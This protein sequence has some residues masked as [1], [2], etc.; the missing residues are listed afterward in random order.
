MEP[1]SRNNGIN[2]IKETKKLFNDV[3]SNLSREETKRVRKK[4]RRIEAVYRILK[5]KEQK[6]SLTSRQKNMLRNDERYLK[7]ISTHLKN[8]KHFKKYQHDID[9]LFNEHNEEDYTSNNDIKAINYV[10]TLL[11]E[12]RSNHSHEEIKRIRKKLCRVEAVSNVLKEKEQKGSLTIKQENMLRNDERYLKNISTHLKNLKKHFKKY[13]Y[14][15]D[16]LLNEHNEDYTSNYDINA[17]KKAKKL[18]NERR[19]NLLLNE[20]KRIRKE[21]YKKEDVYN[22]LKEK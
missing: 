12:L 11:N 1:A 13:Q 8:L 22:F 16:Y 7:N 9:Y 19:S 14:G 21:L 4:L 20:T 5:E 6:D 10:R 15:T 17:F 2:A 18:F 3:R